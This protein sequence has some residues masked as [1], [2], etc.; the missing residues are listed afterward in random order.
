MPVFTA[1]MAS[2]SCPFGFLGT[3]PARTDN[4][5]GNRDCSA[6]HFLSQEAL[7]DTGAVFVRKKSLLQGAK[8]HGHSLR[9]K[10]PAKGILTRSALER[11]PL[12]H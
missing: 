4:R 1:H 7:G 9:K 12:D 11:F 6:F 2:F 3:T 8:V 5:V 10:A